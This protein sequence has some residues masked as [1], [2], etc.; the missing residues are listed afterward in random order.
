MESRMEWSDNDKIQIAQQ[1]NYKMK[2]NADHTI[3][4]DTNTPDQLEI[5]AL[6]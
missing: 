6:T 5:V 4:P 1:Y 2:M 3:F